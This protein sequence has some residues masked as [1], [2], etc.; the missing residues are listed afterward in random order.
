MTYF[1]TYLITIFLAP[2]S[3]KVFASGARRLSVELKVV[4]N[5]ISPLFKNPF[6]KSAGVVLMCDFL[7]PLFFDVSSS[8]QIQHLGRDA[9][10]LR[11][12]PPTRP[13]DTVFILSM[14]LPNSHAV[15]A[16]M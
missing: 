12:V 2:R 8:G 14:A 3:I 11:C 1:C 9:T 7:R 6:D 5:F 4:K 13:I 10:S 15:S 16:S